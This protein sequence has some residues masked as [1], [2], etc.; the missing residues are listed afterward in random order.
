MTGMGR[1][2]PQERRGDMRTGHSD[3]Q[4]ARFSAK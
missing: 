1:D 3:G 2:D 4:A